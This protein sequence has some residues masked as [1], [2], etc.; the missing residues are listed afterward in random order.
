MYG[1]RRRAMHGWCQ[2]I[3]AAREGDGNYAG[4]P[5]R[6]KFRAAALHLD[7]LTYF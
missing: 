4:T 7:R 2:N 5:V 6:D 1:G 3:K